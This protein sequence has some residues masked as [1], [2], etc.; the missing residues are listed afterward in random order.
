MPIPITIRLAS[1]QDFE[2]APEF[3]ELMRILED[4]KAHRAEVLSVMAEQKVSISKATEMVEATLEA[5]LGRCKYPKGGYQSAK[6]V[7]SRIAKRER[8]T[9]RLEIERKQLNLF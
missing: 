4:P 8:E 3:F 2:P 7:A 6:V 5:T 1:A 9:R